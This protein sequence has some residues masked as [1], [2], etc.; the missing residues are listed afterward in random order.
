MPGRS[1]SE[2]KQ[3]AA[4]IKRLRSSGSTACEFCKLVNHNSEQV[5]RRGTHFIIA[6]NIFPYS[7]WD[8]QGVADHLLIIP[9]KHTEKLGDLPPAAAS[10]FITLIDAYEDQGYNVYARAP[11]SSIKSIAHQHTHL[12]KPG[13]KVVKMLIY[14]RKPLIRIVR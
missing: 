9:N 8:Y 3:Y 1:R 12:I 14:H 6:K 2:E 11:K 10:E 4:H 5:I 7:Y 13:G